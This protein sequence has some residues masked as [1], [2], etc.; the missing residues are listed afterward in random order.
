LDEE[1]NNN[2]I[3][4]RLSIRLIARIRMSNSFRKDLNLDPKLNLGFVL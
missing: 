2:K 1:S 4:L 3:R